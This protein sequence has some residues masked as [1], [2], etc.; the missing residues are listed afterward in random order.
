MELI[1]EKE[2]L[3][4]LCLKINDNCF[5]LLRGQ[6]KMSYLNGVGSFSYYWNDLKEEFVNFFRDNDFIVIEEKHIRNYNTFYFFHSSLNENTEEKDVLWDKLSDKTSINY[7][8]QKYNI[9]SNREICNSYRYNLDILHYKG[10]CIT[11]DF[12]TRGSE[13][14]KDR[15][16]EFSKKEL[17][18]EKEDRFL[19]PLYFDEINKQKYISKLSKINGDILNKTEIIKIFEEMIEEIEEKQINTF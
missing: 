19:E 15:H 2:L 14:N 4:K 5:H 8:T 16:I 11:Y 6:I 7:L 9:P 18:L 13:I 12:Y 3:N 17:E 1:E 10:V